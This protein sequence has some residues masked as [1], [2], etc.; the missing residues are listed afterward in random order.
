MV[1]RD[2][3]S[4][5]KFG[6][7]SVLLPPGDVA[8]CD[9]VIETTLKILEQQLIAF[10]DDDYLLLIGDPIAIGMA[11]SVAAYMNDGRVRFLRWD[12]QRSEYIPVA[13]QL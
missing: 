6:P 2:V 8:S 1:V 9:E 3:S 5:R 10:T 7:L 4:A 13:V 12:R 11:T